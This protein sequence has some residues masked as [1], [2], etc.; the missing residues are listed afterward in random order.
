MRFKLIRHPTPGGRLHTDTDRAIRGT[1]AH[2]RQ[3]SINSRVGYHSTGRVVRS[4]DTDNAESGRAASPEYHRG[5]S[6]V[7]GLRCSHRASADLS[8]K[9]SRREIACCHS[10]VG[11]DYIRGA[12]A[13]DSPPGSGKSTVVDPLLLRVNQLLSENGAGQSDSAICVSLDGWHMYRHELDA[14]PDPVEAHWRRVSSCL[15]LA[16]HH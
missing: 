8:Q 12:T 5:S 2:H 10:R 7:G 6:K 15:D 1:T 16:Q 14:M 9:A 13:H 4:R 11:V 3:R